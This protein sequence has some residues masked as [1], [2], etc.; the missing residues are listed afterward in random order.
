MLI[1][2]QYRWLNE[3]M[4]TQG[5]F[6][7]PG[8]TAYL[9]KIR[10]F[11]T[12][13]KVKDVLDYGCGGAVL[14]EHLALPVYNYDPCVPAFASDP[15][16]ADMLVALDVLEHIEDECLHDVLRHMREKFRVVGYVAIA[17]HPDRS[18][19]LPDGRNP[20]RIVANAAWWMGVLE[21]FFDVYPSRS[22]V[23]NSAVFILT[24][25]NSRVLRHV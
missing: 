2:N 11:I 10:A 12:E 23:V 15:P 25:Q 20:H 5:K 6:D 7:G 1:T 16:Q 9:D 3:E 22:I 18:K 8:A 24:P 21:Q 17:T 4:H 19:L 13:F 14:A